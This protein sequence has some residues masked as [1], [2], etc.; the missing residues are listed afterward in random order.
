MEQ[1]EQ[2]V[3]IENEAGAQYAVAVEDYERE[4][5]G[6]YAGFEVISWE[7]GTPVEPPAEEAPVKPA[8]KKAS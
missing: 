4:K 8:K 7:D 1:P 5:D 3:I 2:L 6:A